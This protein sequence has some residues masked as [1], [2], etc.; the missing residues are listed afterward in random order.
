MGIIKDLTLL[1]QASV[2]Q[3][4]KLET[5]GFDLLSVQIDTE[6]QFPVGSQRRDMLIHP[7]D[8]HFIRICLHLVI[9][10]IAAEQ[11]HERIRR[12]RHLRRHIRVTPVHQ[13]AQQKKREYED[14]P[15]VQEE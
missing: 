12:I 5:Q 11:A 2:Q 3:G 4:T 13:I 14:T 1:D 15:A 9:F 8:V 10:H 7:Q 6:I